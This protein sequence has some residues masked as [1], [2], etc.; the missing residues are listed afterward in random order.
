MRFL[1]SL[2]FII[3]ITSVV[4]PLYSFS[5]DEAVARFR[6][7]VRHAPAERGDLH[8]GPADPYNVYE[9]RGNV[10]L[11]RAEEEREYNIENAPPL[12]QPVEINEEAPEPREVPENGK[13]A[14]LP[15]E[16]EEA[17]RTYIPK[18]KVRVKPQIF[19]L[20]E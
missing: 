20:Q 3:F 6:R 13:A 4:T 11:P 15:E 10:D 16:K 2:L 17:P 8:R 14:P 5:E 9:R 1:I 19:E 12:V 18:E 7:P